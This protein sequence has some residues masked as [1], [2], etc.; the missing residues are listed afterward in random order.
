MSGTDRLE[1]CINS[2][3]SLIEDGEEDK[4]TED[5]QANEAEAQ[6]ETNAEAE[7]SKDDSNAKRA[8][9]LLEKIK[10]MKEVADL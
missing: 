2:L 7:E 10:N 9:E 6:P 5:D 3:K 8:G 1:T 4:P